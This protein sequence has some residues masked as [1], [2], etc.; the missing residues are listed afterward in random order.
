M[1]TKEDI[2]MAVD[3]FF[4]PIILKV[5]ELDKS[6]RIFFELLKDFI[7]SKP[8]GTTYKFSA[9]EVRQELNISKTSVFKYIKLLL[10][11]E[12]IQVVEGSANRGF[13]YTIC[14]WDNL[15]KLKNKIKTDLHKQLEYL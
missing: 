1:A 15:D 6:T 7:K 2:R 5:D 4:N 12:Y 11:L 8:N 9:R 3:V 10:K 13:K 14:Y